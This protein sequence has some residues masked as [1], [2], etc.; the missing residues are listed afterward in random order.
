M[1]IYGKIQWNLAKNYFLR[2]K[3]EIS[4]P[5]PRPTLRAMTTIIA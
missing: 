1:C 2:R 4:K 3:K 5:A